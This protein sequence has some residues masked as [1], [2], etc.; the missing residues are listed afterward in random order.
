M[1]TETGPTPSA[2]AAPAGAGPSLLDELLTTQQIAEILQMRVSTVEDYARR[3]NLPSI[4]LRA[5]PTLRALAGR[6]GDPQPGE[7]CAG[8]SSGP[9]RLIYRAQ[10]SVESE[11]EASEHGHGVTPCGAA[12]RRE[13]SCARIVPCPSGARGWRPTLTRRGTRLP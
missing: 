9:S 11:S 6:R 8:G 5:A 12:P 2:P 1:A 4:K 13:W 3:G 10:P 7:P